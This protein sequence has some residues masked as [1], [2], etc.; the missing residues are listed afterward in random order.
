MDLRPYWRVIAGGSLVLLALLAFFQNLYQTDAQEA[1]FNAPLMPLIS[2]IAGRIVTP[3]PA[4]G[5]QAG[6]GT[7][8][9]VENPQVDRSVLTDLQARLSESEADLLGVQAEQAQLRASLERYGQ[10]ASQWQAA[11]GRYLEASLREAEAQAAARQRQVEDRRDEFERL[12]GSRDSLSLRALQAAEAAV[13]VA[14]QERQAAGAR[15]AQI[16]AEREALQ[17]RLRVATSDVERAYSDQKMAETG[18]L[19]RLAGARE[20]ALVAKREA[21][22]SAVTSQS[23][24]L[25]AQTQVSLPLPRAQVWQRMPAGAYVAAGGEIGRL[26]L[27][28]ELV[29]TASLGERE[30]RRLR[31]GM[32]A[33]IRTDDANGDRQRLEGEVIALTGPSFENVMALALPFGRA[34][35]KEAHGV[36]IR[37]Q[38]PSVLDCPIGRTARVSFRS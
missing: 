26:A 27:C 8:V 32:P 7:H 33:D 1:F 37:L 10:D 25:A 29:L 20:V 24:Q 17:R 34:A 22:Q 11:R 18:V 21:L 36:V 5:R 3:L 9:D 19:L 4:V 31:L 35:R 38:D 30:F 12:Q 13:A 16:Q 15:V 2:P 23:A 6:P 28:E 14:E